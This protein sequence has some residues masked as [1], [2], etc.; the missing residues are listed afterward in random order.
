MDD[1]CPIVRSYVESR[2]VTSRVAGGRVSPE[3]REYAR[4]YPHPRNPPESRTQS[5]PLWSNKSAHTRHRCGHG[6][7]IANVRP[8]QIQWQV[9]RAQ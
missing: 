9:G 5:D 4:V 2:R 7:V 6:V 3:C 8:H 1:V